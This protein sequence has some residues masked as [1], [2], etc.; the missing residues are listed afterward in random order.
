MANSFFDQDE[1]DVWAVTKTGDVKVK[2]LPWGTIYLD[3][4]RGY[5]RFHQKWKYVWTLDGGRTPLTAQEKKDLAWTEQEKRDF[6]FG[7]E[8]QIWKAWNSQRPTS[9]PANADQATKDFIQLLNQHDGVL[10]KVSGRAPFAQKF[11]GSGVPIEFDVLIAN[12]HPNWTVTVKKLRPT[13]PRY[14][15][16]VFFEYRTITLDSRDL[17]VDN[18]CNRARPAVCTADFLTVPHEFGHTI[19]YGDEYNGGKHL[20]DSGSIMNVGK[21]VRARHLQWIAQQLNTMVP[22]CRFSLGP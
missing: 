20:G 17:L 3:L 8:T 5:V 6:H 19:H 10:F 13:A 22:N 14:R 12:K 16:N 15:S 1:I 11:A 7:A 18:A 9:T 21:Q 2:K 4:A